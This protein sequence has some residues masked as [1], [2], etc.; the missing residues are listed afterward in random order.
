MATIS[1]VFPSSDGASFDYQYAQGVHLPLVLDRWGQSGLER[2][3]LLRGVS[4]ADGGAPPFLAVGLLRFTSLEHLHAAM[5]GEHAA[6]IGA[7]IAK[8]TNVK[9][10]L[11]VNADMVE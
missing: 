11:Q 9:P 5:T 10:V 1:I 2:V 8:F 4:S 6:E 3:E 7:D